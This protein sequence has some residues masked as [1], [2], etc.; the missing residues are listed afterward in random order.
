MPNPTHVTS[1]FSATG[2]SSSIASGSSTSTSSFEFEKKLNFEF[3]RVFGLCVSKGLLVLAAVLRCLVYW[4]EPGP[5]ISQD[6]VF[7]KQK[8]SVRPQCRACWSL[9]LESSRS[10]S[11]GSG[12]IRFWPKKGTSLT[13]WSQIRAQLQLFEHNVLP[14]E[15]SI[16]A[17]GYS[18]CDGLVSCFL[19]NHDLFLNQARPRSKGNDGVHNGTVHR[20]GDACIYCHPEGKLLHSREPAICNSDVGWLRNAPKWR[21]WAGRANLDRM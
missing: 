8:W 4:S 14:G 21:M 5:D 18:N 3:F 10:N 12:P 11:S 19:S 9:S 7:S 13:L 15:C 17:E 1:V 16:G 20:F 2:S 6:V